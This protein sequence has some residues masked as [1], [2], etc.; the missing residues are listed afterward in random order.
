MQEWLLL[1]PAPLGS[2][3]VMAVLNGLLVVARLR[4]MLRAWVRAARWYQA[5][6]AGCMRCGRVYPGGQG[7]RACS[8][9]VRG[10]IRVPGSMAAASPADANDVPGA[11]SCPLWPRRT[12]KTFVEPRRLEHQTADS[13][14]DLEAKQT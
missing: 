12:R 8:R 9:W 7:M 6:T 11:G 2:A 13:C 14:T 4:V 1:A 5:C 3:G 10:C